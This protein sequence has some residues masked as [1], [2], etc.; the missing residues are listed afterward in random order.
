MTFKTIEEFLEAPHT[1]EEIL[2]Y[3]PENKP[4]R[5]CLALRSQHIEVFGTGLI[6]PMA[7]MTY[8]P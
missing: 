6:C 4:C 8:E 3:L 2:K 5:R 7:A 1:I